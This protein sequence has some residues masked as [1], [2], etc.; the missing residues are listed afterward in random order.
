MNVQYNLVVCMYVYF[1]LAHSR[2]HMADNTL[3]LY[4][5]AY[6]ELLNK[7]KKRKGQGKPKYSEENL[8]R[9]KFLPKSPSK[10]TDWK[11]STVNSFNV[12]LFLSQCLTRGSKILVSVANIHSKLQF[13]LP[14]TLGTSTCEAWISTQAH[15][16]GPRN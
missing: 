1:R 11:Y 15:I 13:V 4:S 3:R 5:L 7:L 8:T 2:E 14:L 6:L 9:L 10:I 16:I 12:H